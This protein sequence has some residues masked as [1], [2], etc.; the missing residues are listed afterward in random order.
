MAVMLLLAMSM[1]A[2]DI[3][4]MRAGVKRFLE[5]EGYEVKVDDEGDMEA[6]KEGSIYSIAIIETGY[7]NC[8]L[9]THPFLYVGHDDIEA[10]YAVN[11]AQTESVFARYH[12]DSEENIVTCIATYLMD[13]EEDF[14]VLWNIMLEDFSNGE[15]FIRG[16]S[17]VPADSF[18]VDTDE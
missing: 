10:L 14:L 9:V 3:L 16:F 15:N 17:M 6:N 1:V 18:A 13:S 11:E 2:G 5:S 7:K 8:L 4:S 12:Y